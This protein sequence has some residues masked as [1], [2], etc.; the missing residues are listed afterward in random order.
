MSRNRMSTGKRAARARLALCTGI[1]AALVAAPSGARAGWCAS[2]TGPDGGFVTCGYATWQQCQAAVS[3]Q[4][5]ICYR[6]PR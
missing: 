3:G 1:V 6:S 5:G 2:A 4:G